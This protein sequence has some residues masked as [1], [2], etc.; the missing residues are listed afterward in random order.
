MPT[1]TPKQ[2]QD[3]REKKPAKKKAAKPSFRE[4]V[5]ADTEGKY[6]ATSWGA[7]TGT[8]NAPHDLEV[9]SGQVCLVRRPG[10]EGLLTAGVLQDID[11]LTALVGETIDSKTKKPG[12]A[13]PAPE[14][15]M[16]EILKNPERMTAV[17]HTVDRT[18]CAVVV[19][20]PIYMAPN[21]VTLR[22]SGVIYTDM[23]DLTD[24]MFIFQYVVGGSADLESFRAELDE[25]VGSLDT[26]QGVEDPSE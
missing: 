8:A 26:E 20:P 4:P 1:N 14:I 17:L 11:T 23:V 25:A 16:N 9:P 10:V 19:K 5:E 22:K 15:D 13:S 6:A 12:E 18:I 2:P 3:K 7:S 21:D 24:K